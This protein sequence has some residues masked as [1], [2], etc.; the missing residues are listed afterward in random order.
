LAV[1]DFDFGLTFSPFSSFS[2]T[3]FV[4]LFDLI[5]TSTFDSFFAFAFEVDFDLEG[6]VFVD[7]TLVFLLVASSTSAAL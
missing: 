5:S 6:A 2:S 4:P 7:S 3:S 1:E